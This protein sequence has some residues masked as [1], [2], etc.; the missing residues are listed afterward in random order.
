LS[1]PLVTPEEYLDYD[2]ASDVKN[3]YVFGVIVARGGELWAE[4]IPGI[5][6][7]LRMPFLRSID[8]LPAVIAVSLAAVF[9]SA[10]TSVAS[11]L[12]RT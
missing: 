6:C 12:I 8:S 4:G 9:E 2:R 7:W 1:R 11:T 5:V 3:E 10:W